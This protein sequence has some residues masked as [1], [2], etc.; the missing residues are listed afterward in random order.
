MT[1][2]EYVKK[3]LKKTRVKL[4]DEAHKKQLNLWTFIGGQV[5]VRNA[6]N[7]F[8]VRNDCE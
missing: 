8:R 1:P 7:T 4:L 2:E 6:S 5:T 3:H